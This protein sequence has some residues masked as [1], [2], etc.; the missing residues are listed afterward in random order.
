MKY[1]RVEYP[2]SLARRCYFASTLIFRRNQRLLAVYIICVN[3]NNCDLN[4]QSKN[5]KAAR[6][7]YFGKNKYSERRHKG[8]FEFWVQAAL[9]L[10]HF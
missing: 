3:L 7:F 2:P 4:L 1:A 5:Q 9:F 10:T 8:T 6:H